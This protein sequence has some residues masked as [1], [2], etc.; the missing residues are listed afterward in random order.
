MPRIR[1]SLANKVQILFSVAVGLILFAALLVPWYR[2]QKLVMEGQKQTASRLADAWLNDVIQLGGVFNPTT[3]PDLDKPFEKRLRLVHIDAKT[4]L[5]DE[6]VQSTISYFDKWGGQIELFETDVALGD[7]TVFRYARAIRAADLKP[8]NTN[9]ADDDTQVANPL[10]GVLIID[11]K[12][13]ES[14]EQLAVNLLYLIIAG[15]LAVVLAIILFWFIITRVILSPVRVLRETTDKVAAGDLNIRADIN[16]GDEFEMLSKA[17]NTM[18]SNLKQSQDQMR[19]LNQQLDVKLGEL[20]QTNVSLHEANQ[21]KG[22]FLANVSHELR[23]PLNSIIGFAGILA[24]EFETIDVKDRVKFVKYARNI[25]TSSQSLL[26]LITEL[27]DLAKIEAGRIDLH[28]DQV[29]IPDLCESLVALMKPQADERNIKLKVDLEEDIPFVITD[30][31]KFRQILFN[32]LS[33]AVKFTPDG[34][35]VEIGAELIR[36]EG[37]PESVRV[38]VTDSG[39]GI[40]HENHERIF[41]KFTQ[42]DSTHTRE[43]SGTGLGL[44]ISRELAFLLRG[45]V[46]LES[47]LGEGATFSITIPMI[48][49]EK[50]E[51]LMPEVAD[52]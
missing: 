12:S 8:V 23:T 36:K 42:L 49:E 4:E 34:G 21:L 19:D 3:Q 40:A 10:K 20:E 22:D 5:K 26:D 43:H 31:L 45:V 39:P 18:L 9:G 38:W 44:A 35:T 37:M 15:I 25:L 46:D 24:D 52:V 7:E 27:L 14:S 13:D 48:L 16:T 47:D 50:S 30:T 28:I 11:M 29:S 32:F 6:F 51:S 2:M 17:F 33:N 1:V 41:D